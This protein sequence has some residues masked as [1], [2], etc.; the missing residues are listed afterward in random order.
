MKRNFTFILILSTL[1][2]GSCRTSKQT[3]FTYEPITGQTSTVIDRKITK[4]ENNGISILFALDH[5][6]ASEMAFDVRIINNTNSDQVISLD[7]ISISPSGQDK[8][9]VFAVNPNVEMDRIGNDNPNSYGKKMVHNAGNCCFYGLIATLVS[10]LW[11]EIPNP[12][13]FGN[14]VKDEMSKNP[15]L[16]TEAYQY[17]KNDNLAVWQ[18][19]AIRSGVIRSKQQLAGKIFFRLKADQKTYDVH[20]PIGENNYS[21][22]IE[23][24]PI[25][26]NL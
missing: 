5:Y 24:V 18:T 6:N 19:F 16:N 14:T 23:R 10:A 7:K 15:D 26:S 4:L 2:C 11:G 8:I 3:M 22:K 1:I 17:H 12:D 13:A 9:E 25:H 21:I 20:L